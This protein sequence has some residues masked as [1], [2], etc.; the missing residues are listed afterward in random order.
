[1]ERRGWIFYR[2]TKAGS[3]SRSNGFMQVQGMFEPRA[4]YVVEG[5]RSE[6]TKPAEDA[7]PGGPSKI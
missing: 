5:R 1:M 7:G 4:E 6:E 3:T 2:D